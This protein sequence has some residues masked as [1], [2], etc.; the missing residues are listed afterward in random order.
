MATYLIK[1]EN[2]G[3]WNSLVEQVREVSGK[4]AIAKSADIGQKLEVQTMSSISAEESTKRLHTGFS[5]LDEV[6]V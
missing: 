5:D 2:C 1:C 4:S 3:E 6:L